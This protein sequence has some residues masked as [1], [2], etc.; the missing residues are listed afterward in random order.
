MGFECGSLTDAP[1]LNET[2]LL[3]IAVNGLLPGNAVDAAQF[4]RLSANGDSF[5]TSNWNN[6]GRLLYLE[7]I[8]ANPEARVVC[9]SCRMDQGSPEMPTSCGVHTPA[10][11][12]GLVAACVASPTCMVFMLRPSVFVRDV[13]LV[14]KG[15]AVGRERCFLSSFPV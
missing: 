3:S 11:T 9:H 10:E 1:A 2:V 15:G 8:G 14:W 7:V 6:G 13:P 4:V 5:D 12:S